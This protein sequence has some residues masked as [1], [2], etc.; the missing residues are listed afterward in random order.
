MFKNKVVKKINERMNGGQ[1][2]E[3]IKVNVI[4][5]SSRRKVNKLGKYRINKKLIMVIK[6]VSR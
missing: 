3:E 6:N 1:R 2:D 4:I 5:S